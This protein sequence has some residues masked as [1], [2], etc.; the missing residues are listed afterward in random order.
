MANAYFLNQYFTT[1][2][3]VGGGIDASQ[4]TGIVLLDV[5]GVDITKP[6]IACLSYSEPLNTSNAE[7]VTY[8]SIDGSNELQGVTRG[9]EGFTAKPHANQVAVAFPLSESHINQLATALSIGGSATNAVTSTVALTSSLSTPATELITA[10]YVGNAVTDTSDT[11]PNPTGD[12]KNNEYYVTA[13]AGAAEFQAPSGTPANGNK[14]LIRVLDDGTSRALTWNAIYDG[15]LADLPSAT[16]ISKTLY[17]LFVYNS[18]AV[19][20]ELLAT[21][22]ES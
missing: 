12:R 10:S 11:T 14:L 20:W 17:C 13:L 9:A 15:T 4:T 19:K 2:L 1:N 8:T 18:E 21:G 5:T 7:W 3:N 16:T 22:E 6:G